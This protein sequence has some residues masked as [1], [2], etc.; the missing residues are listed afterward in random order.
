MS[1]SCFLFEAG[2]GARL[3][4]GQGGFWRLL[5]VV[6]LDVLFHV[7]GAG[8]RAWAVRAGELLAEV[9]QVVVGVVH[10]NLVAETAF[11]SAGRQLN[12]D[13]VIVAVSDGAP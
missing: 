6:D 3:R 12:E 7:R 11:A 5:V 4:Q 9:H 10:D 13:R 8:E 1:G 2:W